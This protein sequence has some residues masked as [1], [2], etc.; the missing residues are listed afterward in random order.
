LLFRRWALR[1]C[2]FTS[3]LDG[4]F[5]ECFLFSPRWYWHIITRSCLHRIFSSLRFLQS[6]LLLSFNL[7]FLFLELLFSQF[8]FLLDFSFD[9]G[10]Y[11]VLCLFF[12]FSLLLLRF[13]LFQLF[14]LKFGVLLNFFVLLLFLFPHF[15]SFHSQFLKHLDFLLLLF[16]FKL[17]FL[18]LL[19]LFPVS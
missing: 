15:L 11:L 9:F 17:L 18:N 13:E 19:S 6:L 2:L 3:L 5:V 16:E 4:V 14:F 1:Q 7:V 8:D 10:L 12:S